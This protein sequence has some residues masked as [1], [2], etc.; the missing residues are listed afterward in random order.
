MVIKIVIISYRRLLCLYDINKCRFCR[1][2]LL[3]SQNSCPECGNKRS[4][5]LETRID[6]K[7]L[8]VMFVVLSMCWTIDGLYLSFGSS[9]GDPRRIVYYAANSF[10]HWLAICTTMWSV[11]YALFN[12]MTKLSYFCCATIIC[13]EIFRWVLRPHMISYWLS[14]LDVSLFFLV[15]LVI[16]VFVC[17]IIWVHRQT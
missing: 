15:V 17:A 16:N 14:P 13:A 8:L 4:I 9:I 6:C 2:A 10:L 5:N 7:M 3:Q 1:Y 11:L 12:G